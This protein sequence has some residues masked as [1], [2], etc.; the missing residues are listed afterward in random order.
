[1]VAWLRV[2]GLTGG[3]ASGK[4]T[5]AQALRDA[6]APV[7]DADDVARLVTAPGGPAYDA[8][9]KA[10][11]DAVL[12]DDGTL[13][14]AALGRLVFADPD[15]RR[16]LESIVHPA[17]SAEI[18]RW[19]DERRKA[20]SAA[21]VL[22]IPL[23]VETGWDRRVDEVWVIDLSEETQLARLAARDGLNRDEARARLAAQASRTRRLAAA[24]RVFV[25]EDAPDA[26]R[27]AVV[28]AWREA[29]GRR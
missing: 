13:D 9:R 8:V 21:A 4:S 1:M 5:A 7:L 2:I 16:R 3:I 20:G 27:D 11:G 19:L 24:T 23:L 14:R 26:L 22:V 12:R 10:F 25:N 29:L 15:A 6:G 18:E 28:R 17:V